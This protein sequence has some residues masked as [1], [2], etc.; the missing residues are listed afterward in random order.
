MRI[1]KLV[2]LV[3]I[4][5]TLGGCAGVRVSQDYDPVTDFSGLKT[6]AWKTETQPKTGDIRV[7]NPLLDGR[8]RSAIDMT[9]ASMGYQK[10]SSGRHDFK[11]SYAY[12]VRTRFESS[13]LSVGTGFGIGGSGS[14]GGVGIGMPVGSSNQDEVFLVIDF[15]DSLRGNLLWRGTGTRR[16]NIRSTPEESAA[17]INTLV[18][19]ILAQ[20]PTSRR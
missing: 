4:I 5:F 11:V 8:I 3:M 17:T 1:L 2:L 9:L 14:Y 19:K 16:V 6:F 7:D 12:G 13:P 15:T 20:F 10:V 18:E